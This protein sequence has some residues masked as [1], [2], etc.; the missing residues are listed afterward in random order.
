MGD[1]APPQAPTGGLGGAP[2][3]GL[4]GGG[5]VT[6]RVHSA[7]VERLRARIAVCRQHHLS[8]E[9]RYER[10]R[11]ESSDRER[12]STLQLLSLVQH[13]QGAR[14]AGKHT[15]ATATAATTTAPP[16][17]PAAPPTVSQA[18]A[19]A[20]PPPP[21]DYH[22]HHQQ[23][24]LSSSNNGG[25]GGIDGEQ[26]P[27]AST[28]ADQRNS[29]LIAL[30][31]SLKR[32]QIVNLS[33]ANSKRPNGFVDNSFLDIKRIRV[34]ENL[35]AG[36]G[37]LQVNNG[38][39]HMM[40]GT[41]PMSQ[42]PLRK[43]A[44][45][46][47]HT[48]SPGNGMFNMGLKEVKKEPG[49]TLSC[50]KHVDG[51][52]TRENI[53]SNRYGD[54]PGEQL[55]DPEL[56]E[57]FNELTN[58][59]VP[60]MSDLELENMINAT[61]KQDD[62]F[63]IDLGQQSQRSTPRPSL[64]MEKTVIKSEYSPGL[65]QGPS[66]SPQ[67]RPSS[68]GPAFSMATSALSASSPIP[69]VPQSQAQPQTA[70]GASRALPSWQEVS[71][72]QQLKQ[73]A[74]NR[75]QHVR[76]QQHQPTSW[77]G[78]P[79]SAGPSPG[80]FGQEKIPSPSF[81]QQP[82]S[83]QS[84]PMPGVVGGGSQSKV[85]ANYMY[86]ASP[87]AQGGPLDVLLQQKPQDLSRSFMNTPHTA[88]EPR[89]GSTK[90]LFHF[91]SDQANQQMPSVLPPQSKPPLLHYTQPQPQ[92]QQSSISA[93]QQQQQQQP[94]P[95]PQQ[96]QPQPQPQ[97]QQ[98]QPQPQPAAQPT[99]PL[100]SQPLLRSPLPLQQK[101]LLQKMQTQPITGLGYQVS[102]QHRQDQHSVV[103]QNTGPSPSPNPC[104]NPN[105]GSGY[106]NSQQSLLNQ[107]L[108]GKKQTLQRQIM[109][110]KQQLLLQQQMLVDTEKIAPQDQINRHLTR[111]PPDYKDQRRNVGNMQP[112]AQ[113][114]GGS[115]TVSLNSNQALANPVS[116]H[117][118]LTPNSSLMSTSHGTRMPS[119]S[120]AVQNIGMYGNLPCNQPGTYSVTSGM[121]QLTQHRNPNQLIANQNNPLM[122]RPPTLGPSNNNNN[123]A[124]FGAGSVGNSQQLRPN[125]TH[126]MAS[127]PAQRTSNV[128]ITSSTTAPNWASQEATTKQQEALKST[129]VRFPPGTPTAYTPNQSLQQ[130][131]G[132]QQ[133]SQR[134]VA[135]PNQ[136]TPAVQIRPMNQMS[137]T[138]NGQNMGPLRSLNLRPNQLST[139]ILPNLSQSGT[140]LS[141]S[142]TSISQP[143]SLTAGSFP[144][145]NQSSRAFQGTDHGNDLAFDFLN[146]QTDNMGPALNS[147][148]DFIDSLLK[149]EPGNDDWMKDINLDEILG[150]NS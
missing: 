138:L 78:L 141:Q 26:Q 54:D 106:M 148:A 81:G 13:G 92:P 142:R 31:G 119:L 2:G 136:L 16:P 82:F 49:E 127:M 18:A 17:P 98:Q 23:H 110:Q 125:L 58:I 69:S 134:A 30:Q 71:H 1:T 123:V 129:G 102:Q 132:S 97:P 135:P 94:Q 60:P 63:S 47:A 114:S 45:L 48:H 56:Q 7:I 122:P 66:G 112:T 65:T 52:V 147:D 76:M 87:S 68:A 11:A 80:P 67:L 140:G 36:Q 14:K 9:G 41:L 53:F 93:Q 12:E 25:S 111:P 124:T 131:V 15:K 32:K 8:C 84:S 133:F 120:T 77:P 6:P 118:I 24:L 19:T 139:Q 38:Q 27:P 42:A 95:Q 130:A 96:P 10:G 4:L 101:I 40:S 37:G 74:A 51:Q 79:S 43:T 91:N 70:S 103:G 149:T 72:A 39:S 83:P 20:A 44:T 33:P 100:S 143:S 75:Q 144:S 86:K 116:T 59:S 145:P 104:S 21:P 34:G 57:L 62:P 150:N 121:N 64:P 146:Q 46:P 3:A 108:M 85:M 107:Q 128:M 50:S 126:S 55:M 35:T 90:P 113:Y 137:Q 117:T 5:S 99:Q 89:H 28:P 73:I 109:E 115:S 105:T 88:M 22:H 61:I 29:A